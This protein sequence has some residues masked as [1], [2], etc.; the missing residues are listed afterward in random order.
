VEAEVYLHSFLTL[1]LDRPEWSTSCPGNFIKAFIQYPLNRTLVR[2]KSQ[3]GHFEE[4]QNVLHLLG[5][6]PQIVQPILTELS[7]LPFKRVVKFVP[8]HNKII[9]IKYHTL[10]YLHNQSGMERVS[11]LQGYGSQ[12]KDY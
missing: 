4:K 12:A 2:L 7:R 3:Y 10:T 11:V 1:V 8:N 6:E 9:I 5:F